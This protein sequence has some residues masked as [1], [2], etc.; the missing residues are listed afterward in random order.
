MNVVIVA[1]E[2]E[3]KFLVTGDEWRGPAGTRYLQGYLSISDA[4]VVRIRIAGRR[5]YLTIKGATEGRTRAEFE[6]EIPHDD[7][8]AMLK[9]FCHDRIVDKTRY[10]LPVD[11]FIWE[12]DEFHG[13]NSG[14]VLAELELEFEGQSFAKPAW[15]GADVS[16]DPRYTSAMLALHPFSM[17]T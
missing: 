14:L 4:G 7:G 2:I 16:D 5:A 15:V 10:R 17:W 9:T 13:P 12:V 11:D 8:Q 6:Y 1:T 3:H